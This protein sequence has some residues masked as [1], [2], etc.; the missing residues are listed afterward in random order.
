M[1][2]SYTSWYMYVPTRIRQGTWMYSVI[3]NWVLNL[4]YYW[5]IVLA[6]CFDCFRLSAIFSIVFPCCVAVRSLFYCTI[7]KLPIPVDQIGDLLLGRSLGSL[8]RRI[9][10]IC[11][12]FHCS[13]R[14]ASLY[15]HCSVVPHGSYPLSVSQKLPMYRSCF[16]A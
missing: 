2:P 11:D 8:F 16:C 14:A 7:W 9:S 4:L 5:A 1:Y 6:L 12:L 10:I 13:F 3:C 15:N